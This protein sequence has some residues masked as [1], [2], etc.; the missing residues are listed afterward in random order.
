MTTSLTDLAGARVLVAGDAMLDRYWF[1]EV[2]RISSEAPVQVVRIGRMEERPGGA[3]NVARNA[4]ALGA[5]VDFLAV[6]G[7]DEPGETLA[8]LLGEDGVR[9]Q[10]IRDSTLRTTVKLRVI[11]RQQ[12]LLR[13]DF[14]D[15]PARDALEVKLARVRITL[16]TGR[17]GDLVGLCEGSARPCRSNDRRSASGR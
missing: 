14:E 4:A 6:V 11:A 8:R 10:L 9:A 16:G 1:G 15:A 7:Q 17:G 2:S 3:A 13:I 12:Q 5:A